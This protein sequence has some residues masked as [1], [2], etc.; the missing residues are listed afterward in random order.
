[1]DA[2]TRRY[3]ADVLRAFAGRALGLAGARPEDARITADGLVAADLRGVHTHG[4]VRLGVYVA[5]LRRRSFDPDAVLSVVRDGGAAVLLDAGA[6]LGIPAVVRAMDLTLDR[7]ARHGIAA[8][9]VRNSSHCGML[10]YPALRAVARGAIGVVLTNADAQVAPWG[11]RAAFLGTNPLA[12]AVPAGHEPPVVLDM[13]TSV[14]PHSR[15][16]AAAARGEAIPLGWALDRDGRPTTDPVAAL[17]GALLPLGGPK[18]SGLA[19]AADIL[20]G[21]LTG[22]RSGPEIASLYDELD[23][24]QG[25]GH[26]CI[27]IAVEAFVPFE[28]FTTRVDALIRSVRALPAADG[29]DRV[30]LPGEIEHTRAVEYAAAGIPLPPHVVAEVEKVAAALGMAPPA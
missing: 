23:R 13:A 6:G 30:Y 7:A 5:R 19:L 15:I 27:A 11:T 24:A 18:G 16:Q 21:L 29:V 8:V 4:V 25:L 17:T 9:G 20:A 22:A 28:Q 2:R 26:L 12:I 1:M 3:K 10:A 14:V